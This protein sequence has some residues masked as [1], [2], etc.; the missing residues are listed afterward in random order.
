MA[1]VITQRSPEITERNKRGVR[2]LGDAILF[3][4]NPE[5][6]L[7]LPSVESA[8][9]GINYQFVDATRNARI[10][11]R[12]RGDHFVTEFQAPSAYDITRVLFSS[13]ADVGKDE[14]G[15]PFFSE[16][17]LDTLAADL[18]KNG[19]QPENAALPLLYGLS[20]RVPSAPQIHELINRAA[21]LDITSFWKAGEQEN[22]QSV[23]LFTVR[24]AGNNARLV[25]VGAQ[26]EITDRDI[27]AL[28]TYIHTQ[29]GTELV[30]EGR[31]LSIKFSQDTEISPSGSVFSIGDKGGR[32]E[33]NAV[34]PI[35]S[36]K[37]Y[38]ERQ[39]G[40]NAAIVDIQ[41]AISPRDTEF[42]TNSHLEGSIKPEAQ[43][44]QST[45]EQDNYIKDRDNPKNEGKNDK[46][47]PWELK[48]ETL[49]AWENADKWFAT[50]EGKE[51]SAQ[52]ADAVIKLIS[53]APDNALPAHDKRHIGK[54]LADLLYQIQQD[55]LTG[56]KLLMLVG[57][58]HDYGRLGEVKLLGK[59]EGGLAGTLHPMISFDFV[60]RI[61]GP[62][63]AKDEN[64]KTRI[65]RL[66]SDSLL[67][68]IL[69]HQAGNTTED[70]VVRRIQRADRVAGLTGAEAWA[71]YVLFD[72]GE[73][74]NQFEVTMPDAL[75]P[76]MV[77]KP[78]ESTDT[79]LPLHAAFY[80]RNLF[81]NIG[82]AETLT[83]QEIDRKAEVGALIWLSTSPQER[84]AIFA[85]ELA[86]EQGQDA[87]EEYR[88]RQEEALASFTGNAADAPK[89]GYLKNNM[90]SKEV[91]NRMQSIIADTQR[92][93]G[94]YNGLIEPLMQKPL[95]EVVL[96]I[97]HA[98]SAAR[99]ESVDRQVLERLGNLDDETRERLKQVMALT[100][101]LQRGDDQMDRNLAA[102]MS[103]NPN[104][105]V[106][107]F[108]GLMGTLFAA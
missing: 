4:A 21:D 101:R 10:V 100:L 106:S 33:E 37:A 28:R 12:Q 17:I 6:N 36:L 70:E 83:R 78:G 2:L 19:I 51:V 98:P 103:S 94:Y 81:P 8:F 50:A 22:Q 49:L 72:V 52:I 27:A 82:N 67:Y 62:L 86:R 44:F 88:V 87:L 55:G 9:Q 108:A 89:N 68:G 15:N 38:R 71:R 104:Y 46:D 84:N 30:P 16:N 102:T 75:L 3:A 90:L 91:W 31:I 64:D 65:P 80:L 96:A 25:R 92:Q 11:M 29:E 18:I 34:I 53:D 40:V 41:R 99:M 107:A 93:G 45:F 13:R 5:S 42:F 35:A 14:S 74:A 105:V 43:R 1:E 23:G 58:L 48:P 39:R 56:A 97:M 76:Y 66:V 54:D 73:G 7:S 79:S 85:F 20:Q 61:L 95:E 24:D 69:V 32:L 57:S 47:I 59:S 26:G 60:K 63:T 77:P